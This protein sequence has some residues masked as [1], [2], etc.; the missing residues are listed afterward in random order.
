MLYP[1][2]RIE[3]RSH[4]GVAKLAGGIQH[5]HTGRLPRF[6]D[7]GQGVTSGRIAPEKS[8]P[9]VPVPQV[10]LVVE[11]R[12]EIDGCGPRAASTCDLKLCEISRT[13]SFA[14]CPRRARAAPWPIDGPASPAVWPP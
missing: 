7:Q 5:S 13:S 14:L 2:G 4:P 6:F 12:M 10:T 11:P 3:R 8:S 1:P 9:Q